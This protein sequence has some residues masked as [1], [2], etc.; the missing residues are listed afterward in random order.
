MSYQILFDPCIQVPPICLPISHHFAFT[1]MS[2]WYPP[3]NY[4]FEAATMFPVRP[5][6]AATRCRCPQ[7]IP[8]LIPYTNCPA[9][10]S[11]TPLIRLIMRYHNIATYTSLVRIMI[12]YALS[13][14]AHMLSLVFYIL[15]SASHFLF[16]RSGIS[17][18]KRKRRRT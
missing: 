7:N 6:S 8:R 11:A 17:A 3:F 13:T 14:K 5:F 12:M 2:K 15:S 1:A 18:R 9:P 4:D 16:I 10:I